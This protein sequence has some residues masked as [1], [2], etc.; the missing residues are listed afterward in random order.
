MPPGVTAALGLSQD[1]QYVCGH[2]IGT[3]VRSPDGNS[4]YHIRGK[5]ALFILLPVVSQH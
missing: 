5:R 3:H 2:T 1:S 4:G